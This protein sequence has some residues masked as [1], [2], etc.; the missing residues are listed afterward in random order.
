MLAALAVLA[1]QAATAA[2]HLALQWHAGVDSE[3]VDDLSGG[4]HRGSTRDTLLQAGMSVR[5]GPLGGLFH[6]SV[7]RIIS[8]R[9]SQRLIGDI[10]TASNIDAGDATR[11]Y[12]L[13][14]ARHLG[15]ALRLR[16]GLVDL[17]QAF[18]VT[19]DAGLFL[20][21]SFGIMPSL[22]ANA[23]SS[24]YPQPG[25]GAMLHWRDRIGSGRV[26]VFQGQPQQRGRP[27]HRG[28]L[29]I[30]QHGW[31]WLQLGAWR[32]HSHADG[33]RRRDWGLYGLADATLT[34]R[35][36]WSVAGFAQW[37]GARGGPLGVRSYL[38]GGLV[39]TGIGHRSDDQLGLA[40]ARAHVAGAGTETST[41][42][43]Y[44]LALDRQ[45]VLQPD[46]Q[47]IRHPSGRRD[48]GHATV[49]MLRLRASMH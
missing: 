7:E 30:A 46:L 22:T 1:A 19:P 42:L 5:H 3:F 8:G 47:Y 45:L 12:E 48:I 4:L 24:I 49:F 29:L 21:S 13:W 9:P 28:E 34:R 36:G 33:M 14:Y 16:A 40:L 37:G 17:N 26:G 35:P 2:D 10:Q 25:L 23:A 15:P 41:E 18:L 38:G 43:S 27:L 39:L 20:N 44:A 31:R 32:Y 11:V 6:V